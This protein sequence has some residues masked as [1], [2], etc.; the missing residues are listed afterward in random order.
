MPY[1]STCAKCEKG[2]ALKW[3]LYNG[4]V[5]VIVPLCLEHGTPLTELVNLVGPKP[6]PPITGL[7]PTVRLPKARPLSAAQRAK[8]QDR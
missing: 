8:L 3:T 2:A 7:T 1:R 5:S 6:A 4:Q